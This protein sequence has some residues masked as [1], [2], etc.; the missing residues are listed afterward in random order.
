MV[1]DVRKVG[2]LTLSRSPLTVAVMWAAIAAGGIGL[3]GSLAPD[4]GDVEPLSSR[5]ED[6]GVLGAFASWAESVLFTP[7]F[8][9]SRLAR[10][11]RGVVG[12]AGSGSM[13]GLR[14]SALSTTVRSHAGN[15]KRGLR[16]T[17]RLRWSCARALISVPYLGR[18][19]QDRCRHRLHAQKKQGRGQY[20]WPSH[21]RERRRAQLP[22]V[23]FGWP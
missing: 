12:G 23:G 16:R 4:P 20:H 3:A 14:A 2:R 22:I 5:N 6:S 18:A 9:V 8:P 13:R 15:R 17:A 11:P 10:P 19:I 21:R 1:L 7:S